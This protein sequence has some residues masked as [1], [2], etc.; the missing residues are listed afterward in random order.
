MKADDF[1][2]IARSF[3]GVAEVP[4]FDRRAFKARRIFATLAPDECSGN[5]FLTPE[6]QT[7]A[8]EL[9][10]ETISRIPNRWGF[11]GWTCMILDAADP[12]TARHLLRLAWQASS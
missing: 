7:L 1:V 8:L 11:R 12:S 3:T 4:H 10:P 9:Y 2:Q 6:D 5:I